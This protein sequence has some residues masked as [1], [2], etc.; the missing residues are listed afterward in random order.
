MIVQPFIFLSFCLQCTAV[1]AGTTE[2]TS[3]C[4]Y[5]IQ[6]PVIVA[7]GNSTLY[8]RHDVTTVCV[9]GYDPNTGCQRCLQDYR[10]SAEYMLVIQDVHGDHDQFLEFNL[11]FGGPDCSE[12][13]GINYVLFPSTCSLSVMYRGRHLSF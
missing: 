9:F 7:R 1:L 10:L 2:L 12:I 8:V 13:M 4:C 3:Q 5:L 11:N 6:N